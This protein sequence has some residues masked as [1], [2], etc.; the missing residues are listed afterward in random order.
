MRHALGLDPPERR[1]SLSAHDFAQALG[2][3]EVI[4]AYPAKLAGAPTVTSRFVQ[5]LAAVA[6]EQCWNRVRANGARYLTWAR[7]LDHPAEIKRI[8]K[9]APRPPRAAR[10]SALSVTDIESWLRD[11]YT[12]YAK[13][14]LKLRELDPVDLPPGA[15]DRG[16]FIHGALSEFTKTFASEL[17]ADPG[18]ALMEIGARHFA[19][20]EAYPEAR[21]FW[22]PRFERIARWFVGWERERRG[23]VAVLLAESSGKIDIPLGERTFTLRARADRIER[24]ASGDYAILDYKTGTVPTEKQV[25]IGISPQ[26][27]LEAAILRNGGFSDAPAGASVAELVY[28][29]LKGGEPAG[30]HKPIDLKDGNADIHAD[31]ALAKLKAVAERFEDEQQPYLPLI[32]SMWKSR[33]GTYDH[34][35]RVKEWSVGGDDDEEAGSVE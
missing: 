21:A 27:T 11:P 19:A 4:L 31:R 16:I 24:L 9:P 28:V 32:L 3:D 17:P 22:W 23:Q 14:I 25:R 10:P 18:R 5:R 26:L 8:D 1:I 30:E 13:H 35:A 29:S 33:Y 6:G 2:A 7:A 20:L 15:A 12:I 34:L